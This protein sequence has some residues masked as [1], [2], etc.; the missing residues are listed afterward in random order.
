MLRAIYLFTDLQVLPSDG[1]SLLVFARLVQL[2]NLLTEGFSL[3]DVRR[4]SCQ[5]GCHPQHAMQKKHDRQRA[6]G[7]PE[8]GKTNPSRM[9]AHQPT[10]RHRAVTI[11]RRWLQ[12]SPRFSARRPTLS[13]TSMRCH[14]FLPRQN[15]RFASA[16][17]LRVN[18][19]PLL[20]LRIRDESSASLGRHDKRP[21]TIDRVE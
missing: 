5:A 17:E 9:L 4:P 13:S 2:N 12:F 3:E 6:P 20:L 11:Q 16:P 19:V 21:C 14:A 7:H 10:K 18:F 8:M 1:Q 15:V